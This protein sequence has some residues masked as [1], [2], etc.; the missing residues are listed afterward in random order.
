M[1]MPRFLAAPAMLLACA[2][3]A[4]AETPAAPA[5]EPAE[6]LETG[7]RNA[8][9]ALETLGTLQGAISNLREQ[10]RVQRA[11]LKKSEVESERLAITRNIDD[12]ATRLAQLELDFRA[13]ATGIDLDAF[14][15]GAASDLKWQQQV[16]DLLQ[17]LL[18]EMRQVTSESRE[19]EI[20]RNIVA[21]LESRQALAMRATAN[22]SDL[23]KRSDNPQLTTSL[24]QELAT[25][26]AYLAETQGQLE[27]TRYQLEE[28]LA[29]S[30]SVFNRISQAFARFFRSRG[31]NL[32][33]ALGIFSGVIVVFRRLHQLAQHRR[34]GKTAS[35]LPVRLLNLILYA[36]VIIG[37]TFAALVSLYLADDWVL[38][39][40]AVI[41]L[42]AIAWGLKS[43]I[44]SFIEQI[45]T[46]LNL[47]SVREGERV[48]YHGLPWKVGS[49]NYF[50]T[51]TNPA[52]EGATVRLPLRD[53]KEMISRPCAPG[54]LWFPS[55][56][57]DWVILA[58]GTYGKVVQQNPDFVQII[59]LGGARKT[60]PTG[61]FLE[62][63]PENLTRN[64]RTSL[65]F[66][67]D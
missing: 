67:I 63:N 25:W 66:G 64:F 47:G 27:A 43:T 31:M 6:L 16:Q 38:L 34:H 42:V 30:P 57:D 5:A 62:Q 14:Q 60:Y 11:Q 61:A 58:D 26:K 55:E 29:A 15:A 23:L 13:V 40:L 28:R 19:M 36:L 2:L 3:L 50:T 24:N 10:L 32:L 41:F 53:L 33:I 8:L 17:P 12:L 18:A 4:T 1:T 7:G 56:K 46:L 44:P 22:V 52:L 21:S 65:T 54:E 51:F 39:T 37:A 59:Q 45:R 20:L 49:L 9:G 35:G 48:I